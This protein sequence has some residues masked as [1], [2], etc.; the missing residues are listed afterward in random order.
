MHLYVGG[1][2]FMINVAGPTMCVCHHSSSQ[3]FIPINMWFSENSRHMP[4]SNQ[5]IGII[6]VGANGGYVQ[7][8]FEYDYRPYAESSSI[9]HLVVAQNTTIMCQPNMRNSIRINP[10][11]VKIQV[12]YQPR[13]M[14]TKFKKYV[15]FAINNL[16]RKLNLPPEIDRIISKYCGHNSI[17]IGKNNP[18]DS[19]AIKIH[20]INDSSTE[21]IRYEITQQELIHTQSGRDHITTIQSMNKHAIGFTTYRY[22]CVTYIHDRIY[23]YP[24]HD[25]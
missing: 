4:L 10:T 24:V 3:Y 21:S 2:P 12:H 22:I 25:E 7:G 9:S 14:S 18:R 20:Q 16:V 11:S 6:V 19:T 1:E 5:D 15:E 13:R 23:F 8:Q 17:M